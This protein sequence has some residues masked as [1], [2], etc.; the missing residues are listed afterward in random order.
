MVNETMARRHWPEQNALGRRIK[1]SD[2]GPWFSIVGIVGD[3]KQQ[4]ARIEARAQTLI[5]YWQLPEPGVA[6]VLK[7]H[8]EPEALTAPLRQAVRSVDPDMPVSGIG[9]MAGFVAESIEEPRFLALLVGLFAGLALVL[10]AIGIY[11]VLAYAVSQRTSEIGVRMALGAGRADVFSL[12]VKDGLTLT[13]IGAVL[14]VVASLLV[15]PM[16][17]TLLFGVQPMDPLTFVIVVAMILAVAACASIIPARRGMRV[18][19]L[20]ALRTE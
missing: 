9:T 14:G 20:A 11:G 6:I 15:A 2:D 7:T 3:V 4:G 17:S 19:P 10:A 5:P 12:I 1:F 8:G 16:L 18:D 13:L